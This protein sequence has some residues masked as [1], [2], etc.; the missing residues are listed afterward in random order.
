[1]SCARLWQ[2][3]YSTIQPSRW[4]WFYLLLFLSILGAFAFSNFGLFDREM[5]CC[6]A[7]RDYT[8]HSPE[9][10]QNSGAQRANGISFLLCGFLYLG[11]LRSHTEERPFVCSWPGCGKGF[12]RSHD[13]KR[14]Q[15]LHTAKSG[16]HECIGCGK[17]FSRQDALNRHRMYSD[18]PSCWLGVLT[19][20]TVKSDAA[21]LC[22]E[23]LSAH[24]GI[25]HEGSQAATGSGP[26]SR[27]A[28]AETPRMSGQ[29]P[30]PVVA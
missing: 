3:F 29:A 11:H 7:T 20:P 16:S 12:A 21:M 25:S 13:C 19:D 8:I 15:A 1:M 2:Y 17:K 27:S 18:L 5:L 28:S 26:H 9:P 4:V 14:H 23:F 6:L 24:H 22:R 10:T 30:T